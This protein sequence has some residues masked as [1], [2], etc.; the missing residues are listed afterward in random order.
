MRNDFG[1]CQKCGIE[2]TENNLGNEIGAEEVLICKTCEIK[3]NRDLI[4]KINQF[5]LSNEFE[6]KLSL[7]RKILEISESLGHMFDNADKSVQ[8][9]VSDYDNSNLFELQIIILDILQTLLENYICP[10]PLEEDIEK[11]IEKNS[12]MEKLRLEVRKQQGK[13][14]TYI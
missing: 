9:S 7:K 2:I 1:N 14:A 6:N 13:I 11:A 8:E 3:Y 10:D 5:R 4:E 12:E